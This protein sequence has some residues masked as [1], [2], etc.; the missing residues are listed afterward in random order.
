MLDALSHYTSVSMMVRWSSCSSYSFTIKGIWQAKSKLSYADMPSNIAACYCTEWCMGTRWQLAFNSL[1]VM[2]SLM[3]LPDLWHRH[4][5]LVE[6]GL[7]WPVWSSLDF[8]TLAMGVK[9]S[10]SCHNYTTKH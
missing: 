4:N 9:V 1:V 8:G 3:L 6:N 7:W 5:Y 2:F 10:K